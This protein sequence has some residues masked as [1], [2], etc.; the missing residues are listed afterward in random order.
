[1]AIARALANRPCL[2]LA[3]EPTGALDSVTGM[4]IMALLQRLREQYRMTTLVVTNDVAVA[5]TADRGYRIRDGRVEP[6]DQPP[7][8]GAKPQPA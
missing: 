4:R 3:D 2:L 5:A 1:M 8:R 6:L 7:T